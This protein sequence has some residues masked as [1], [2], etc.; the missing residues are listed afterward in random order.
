[1]TIKQANTYPRPG[2]TILAMSCPLF[3][4]TAMIRHTFVCAKMSSKMEIKMTN[5]KLAASCCVNTVVCVKNP[6]PMADVAI[7][8]A[9]PISIER[10]PFGAFICLAF[11]LFMLFPPLMTIYRKALS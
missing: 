3:S 2:R 1:M 6:G 7:K 5:P 11:S 8:K 10:F 9:A 4:E